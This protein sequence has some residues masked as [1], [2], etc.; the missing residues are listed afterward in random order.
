M[1]TTVLQAA[2]TVVEKVLEASSNQSEIEQGK[3]RYATPPKRL[4][5]KK[6]STLDIM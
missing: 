4:H 5:P 1:N 6:K 3:I 2:V